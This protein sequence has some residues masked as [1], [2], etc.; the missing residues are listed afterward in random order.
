MSLVT[1]LLLLTGCGDGSFHANAGLLENGAH[2]FR[3]AIDPGHGGIDKG[4]AG[5]ETGTTEAELKSWVRDRLRSSRTPVVVDVRPALPYN[6]TGKLLR[7]VLKDE[8]GRL[9]ASKEM[10]GFLRDPT[11]S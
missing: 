2:G 5:T 8:L 4:A 7:R 9:A 3:I 10:P 1:A 11:P 6:E